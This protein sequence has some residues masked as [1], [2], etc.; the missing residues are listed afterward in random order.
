MTLEK[1]S[2]DIIAVFFSLMFVAFGLISF[3]LDYSTWLLP[4][5]SV[6]GAFVL[7]TEVGWKR[8]SNLH[9]LKTLHAQQYLTL[10]VAVVALINGI[11]NLPLV[12]IQVK[13]L[14]QMGGFVLIL[15]GLM[16][17]FEWFSNRK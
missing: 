1:R 17:A 7:F 13:F 12:N 11:L 16:V 2:M 3:G 6:L 9:S 10:S 15:L 5:A 14:Q 8:F 4:V